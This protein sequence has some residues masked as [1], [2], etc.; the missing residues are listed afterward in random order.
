MHQSQSRDFPAGVFTDQTGQPGGRGESL[1]RDP[2]VDSTLALLREGYPFLWNRRQRLGSPVFALRLMMRDTICLSGEEGARLFY[3]ARLFQRK[4]AAPIR[5]KRTLF[6]PGAVQG[7]DEAAHLARKAMFLSL[8]TEEHV[9]RLVAAA[10]AEWRA[11]AEAWPSGRDV[12][13]HEAAGEVLVSAVCSWAGVPLARGEAAERARDIDLVLEGVGGVGPRH[14]RGRSARSRCDKWMAEVVRRG[15]AGKIRPPAGSPLATVLAY[16]EPDGSEMPL[17]TAAAELF[18]LVRPTVAVSRFIVF[19]ALALHEQPRCR[20]TLAACAADDP[21]G[22]WFAQE[23]RRFYPFFPFVAAR[24]RR[25]F[26]WRGFRFR[27]GR[28]VLLDLYGTDRDPESWGDPERFRPERFRDWSGNA[29]KFIP[30]GGGDVASGH[31]CPGERIT[32]GLMKDAAR[33]L[34]SELRHEVPPQDLSID[35]RH[36][37]ARPASGFVLRRLRAS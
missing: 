18:N 32:V 4:N 1:P 21:Y 33:W 27:A 31:R 23:V 20:A 8:T 16:R 11:A 29:F 15:R 14:W 36:M 26:T 30:Q 9:D 19:A 6:G 17:K 28:R 13:L 2:A 7:L 3:D 10:R 5:L 22:E 35:L 25:D 24:V 34:A 12:V 37:P